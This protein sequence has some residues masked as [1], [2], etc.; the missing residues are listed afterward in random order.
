MI[1]S[2]PPLAPT[3][4]CRGA[5]K[6]RAVVRVAVARHLETSRRS[7]SPMAIGLSPPFFFQMARRVAPQRW[8][9]MEGGA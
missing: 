2:Q 4:S 9:R 8:G 5:S 3:P 7:T 6:E 1:A